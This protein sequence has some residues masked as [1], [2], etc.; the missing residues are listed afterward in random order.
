MHRVLD[1]KQE[2]DNKIHW[3]EKFWFSSREWDGE[4]TDQR[5]NDRIAW[6]SVS[7]THHS[8]VITFHKLGDNL[9]RV[10]VTVDF[11]P[12]GVVE[13]M[14][15]GMRFVKRAVQGDLARFKAYVELGDAEG[16]EYKST[17]AEMEQHREGDDDE[18]GQA[19][20][21]R[22]QAEGRG[23]KSPQGDGD[24]ASEREERESRRQE[25]RKA[26]SSS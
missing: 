21:E 20:R 10:M 9:T 1:V 15:S 5:K 3:Q 26:L 7:G 8:G 22:Q 24:R 17:P 14:A 16:L 13:K 4:I 25:R 2:G 19:E 11:V 23:D 6:K 18:E 12:Q